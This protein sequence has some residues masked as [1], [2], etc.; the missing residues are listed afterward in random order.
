MNSARI[1]LAFLFVIS[2]S[3][4][5]CN[6]FA[7]FG[8]EV[9]VGY[10]QQ[11]PSGFFSYE[12]ISSLDRID[13]ENDLFYEEQNKPFVRV[14][15]ELPLILP[16]LYFMATPMTFEGAGNMSRTDVNYGGETFSGT[17]YVESK[18]KLDHYDLALF[19]PIPLLK[20]ATADTL[21]IELGLNI[22][23]LVFEGT[24]A[25]PADG[26]TSASDDV[27]L[28]VPMLYV[29][30][31]VEPIEVLSIEAELRMISYSGNSYYDYLGRLKYSPI[32]M[33]YVAGGYRAE[34][35]DIDEEDVFADLQFEGPFLE[36]G[37]SF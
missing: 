29:G 7:L 22:R 19:Y 34:T 27:S 30:V 32:P 23:N 2:M 5:P 1:Y 10:W 35:I 11:S 14:K 6:A 21:N 12:E 4:V 9:G 17:A 8:A 16:N 33:V 36:V 13:L 28:Y 31:Q 3:I 37:V 26:I 15:V 25:A 20:T 18:L 24:L